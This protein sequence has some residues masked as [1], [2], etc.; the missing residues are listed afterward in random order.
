MSRL[1]TILFIALMP[2]GFSIYADDPDSMDAFL[3]NARDDY[4]SFRKNSKSQLSD[5]RENVMGSFQNYRDSVLSQF[6]KWSQQ[7]WEPHKINPPL[8]APNH[9]R[10]IPPV[11]VP[12]DSKP[13][14]PKE[15]SVPDNTVSVP[16]PNRDTTAPNPIFPDEPN[17]NFDNKF[18]FTSYGTKYTAD[19]PSSIIY[20][21][22]AS[23]GTDP[24]AITSMTRK[25]DMDAL[26][27]LV[28]SL[29]QQASA[30][31]LSDW[32]YYK[33]VESFCDAF[34]SDNANRRKIL[35]GLVLALSGYKIRFAMGSGDNN[36]YV[37]TG[38][39]DIIPNQNYWLKEDTYYYPFERCPS[40]MT[41]SPPVFDN[42]RAL[43]TLPTGTE[44]FDFAP[45]SPRRIIVCN[46]HPHCAG[47]HCK[48]PVLDISLTANRNRLDF[49]TDCPGGMIPGHKYSTWTNY[50]YV[51]ISEEVST[52]L[53]PS[54][55]RL[56]DGMSEEEAANILMNFV[57]AFDYGL[58]SEVWGH[59]RT[60][61]AEETLHYPL[62]DCE[63]GAIL[64]A[65][66]V[67]DLLGLPVA[68]IYYPGHL[69]AAVAFTTPVQGAYI[70]KNSRRYTI[71]DP[72][73]YYVG[74]GIQMP[75]VDSSRATLLPLF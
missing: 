28:S 39:S 38:C 29:R 15:E 22:P 3:K 71:C 4:E 21:L 9:E 40:M 30:H 58:D 46:H 64:F 62:R 26:Q 50:A 53:Y 13:P 41:L 61:F 74:V 23:V 49:Y 35:K 19:A 57:E 10:P 75:G 25:L 5:F 52:Q 20:S 47:N 67:H 31:R 11:Y 65:R 2:L 59:E 48:E 72:T 16:R 73:Y 27:K 1:F 70:S 12:R 14:V 17:P 60:F 6:E 68:L 7:P 69:A 44:K 56:I 55:R 32:A 51:P 18:T 33:M 36:V 34:I 8:P 63:D 45:S 43:S 66:L 42:T 24:S 37:L 54:L